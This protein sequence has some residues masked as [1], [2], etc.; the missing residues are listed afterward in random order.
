M[1]FDVGSV[2]IEILHWR[3]RVSPAFDVV[4]KMLVTEIRD[5]VAK[6]RREVI[7]DCEVP[8]D[9]AARLAETG[10]ETLTAA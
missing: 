2:E 4:G 10:A 5:G 3:R 8:Q 9:R 7:L 6:A 1:R